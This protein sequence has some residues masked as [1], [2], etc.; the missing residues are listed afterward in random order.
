APW[1]YPVHLTLAP[2]AAAVAAGNRAMVKMSELTP[3]TAALLAR[4][5]A[6]QFGEDEIFIT[7]GEVEMARQ[8]SSLPFDHLLFTG[9]TAVGRDVMRAA[10]EN[11]TPVTLELGGKS[12]AVVDADYPIS[13]AASRITW[14]K[15]FNSGQ[16]CVAPD[17]VLVPQGSEQAFAEAA[18]AAARKFQPHPDQDDDVTAIVSDRHYERI[19][20]L[21]D[22]ARAKG[23]TVASALDPETVAPQRKLPFTVVTGVDD[24]M[25][26]A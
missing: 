11:L 17:Y 1:N 19:R 15:L 12:P 8:F 10:A 21:L 5:V 3:H 4:L 2:L 9:S 25:R 16:T 20:S 24:G 18:V 13:W 26:L 14:G 22:D 7:G 6:E 23:A